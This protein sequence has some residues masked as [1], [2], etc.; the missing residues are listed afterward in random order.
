MGV[1]HLARPALAH[2]TIAQPFGQFCRSPDATVA[3]SVCSSVGVIVFARLTGGPLVCICVRVSP[4]EK[5]ALW[6]LA[7]PPPRTSK[8]QQ[9]AARLDNTA[10][11]TAVATA[12]LG[13][14]RYNDRQSADVINSPSFFR[15]KHSRSHMT[16]LLQIGNKPDRA[17]R[18]DK[19]RLR[20]L[21]VRGA[22]DQS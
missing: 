17:D 4:W 15:A 10:T 9:W 14:R 21:S 7:Y 22:L 12:S 8:K 11:A 20:E 13:G 2:D 16:T 18:A 3:K 6:R 5:P 1:P 19:V